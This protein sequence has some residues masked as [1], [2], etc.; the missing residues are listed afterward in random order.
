MQLLLCPL[1]TLGTPAGVVV[2]G[3]L[4]YIVCAVVASVLPSAAAAAGGGGGA[5]PCSAAGY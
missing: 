1:L 4:P 2:L 3:Q 5:A